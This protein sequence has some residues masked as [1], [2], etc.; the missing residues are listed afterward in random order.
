MEEGGLDPASVSQRAQRA[1]FLIGVAL[2]VLATSGLL[3]LRPT[4][5]ARHSTP[6]AAPPP[7]GGSVRSFTF[8]DQSAGWAVLVSSAGVLAS[9]TSMSIVRTSDGGRHWK[10]ADVPGVATYALTRFFDATHGIVSVSTSSGQILYSTADGGQH[11]RSSPLPGQG[12]TADALSV[13]FLDPRRGW[14]LEQVSPV[15]PNSAAAQI[16]QQ[17]LWRTM[18][19]GASWTQLLGLDAAHQPA[20]GGLTFGG[21]KA[22]GNFSDE[23]RGFLVSVADVTQPS[24]TFYSTADGGQTWAPLAVLPPPAALLREASRGM[25]FRLFALRDQLVEL[26]GA[27]TPSGLS[28][29]TRL[30]AD[31]G[32]SWTALRPLPIG[33]ASRLVLPQFEDSRHWSLA[34][35]RLLWRTS[36]AGETWQ[37]RPAAIP[38]SLSISDLQVVGRNVM[39]AVAARDEA[40][41]AYDHLLRSSDDG[42]H[43]EDQGPPALQLAS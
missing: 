3:Y 19:G 34:A 20:A 36:D 14:Y 23:R 40:P 30:S 42:A 24:A 12:S 11:W 25:S 33:S 15:L 6:P 4:L 21:F 41:D 17:A 8:F 22:L 13:V 2:V 9:N 28:Y 26:V 18:D 29:F 32:A 1:L 5:T 37:S 35:G 43:W 10:R 16:P 31:G 39:W 7:A 38:A 27:A